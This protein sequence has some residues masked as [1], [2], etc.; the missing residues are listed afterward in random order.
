MRCLAILPYEK[1]FTT[2]VCSIQSGPVIYTEPCSSANS[3]PD[4]GFGIA[5]P[6]YRLTKA[7]YRESIHKGKNR[8]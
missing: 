3:Q 2:S 4:C 5:R 7:L 8:N 6:L 1:V